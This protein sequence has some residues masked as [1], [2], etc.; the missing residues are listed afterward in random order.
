[1]GGIIAPLIQ[2]PISPKGIL[3]YGTVYRPWS[4]FLLEMHRVQKPLLEKLDAIQTEEFLRGIQAIYFDFFVRK[5]TPAELDQVTAY[6]KLVRS[7]LEYA[8]GKET[9]WGRHW[10]FWQQLDSVNLAQAWQQT[11]AQ[12][13]VM[14]GGADYI[15][16]SALEPYLIR[17]AVNRGVN[18]H[19]ELL[20][21]PDMD[22]LLLQSRNFE[23]AATRFDRKDY[24]SSELH[25]DFLHKTTAWMKALL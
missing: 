24:L 3:V 9:M 11:K 1:M 12:V 2:G 4:E 10:R 7:E 17:E 25:P 23:D 5:K 13:L 6:H 8:D 22:H 21:F 15:Q 19:A 20:I 16:C 18:G 14:H